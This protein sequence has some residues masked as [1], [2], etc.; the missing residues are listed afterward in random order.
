METDSKRKSLIHTNKR[1]NLCNFDIYSLIFSSNFYMTSMIQCRQFYKLW[2]NT[3]EICVS[4]VIITR[5]PL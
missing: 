3:T 2:I 1:H 5:H 4:Q